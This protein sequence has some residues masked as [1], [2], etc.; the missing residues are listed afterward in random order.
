VSLVVRARLHRGSFELNVDVAFALQGVTALFGR[1]GCGKTTLL[2]VIAGLERARNAEVTFDGEIWQQGRRFVPLHKRR[3]GLVFQ[4]HSLLANLTVRQNLLYGYERTPRP[5]RR[6]HL[7]ETVEMLEIG[8]LLDRPIDRLSGGERQRASLGRAL[9]TSPRMLLLDE[10]L[11]ALDVQT[12]RE[13]MPF[14]TRLAS[15][16]GVPIVLVTHAADEVERLADRVAF[17]EGGRIDRVESLQAA[18]SR[19]D[20]PLFADEGAASIFEGALG[21][22]E[23]HGLCPFGS[24]TARLWIPASDSL[25]T[26]APARVRILARDVALA[27]D[28]PR[29]IS[30][31]NRLWVT[32]EQIVPLPGNRTLVTTRTADGARLLAEVTPWAVQQLCLEPGRSVVALIKSVALMP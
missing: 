11:A 25:D 27:L 6:Q 21:P 1:S 10:P 24:P 26:A 4:E 30:I 14:L 15:D 18:M 16:A 12:K 22:A 20:S 31:R 32:I 9:L 13:I 28:D 8:G 19:P 29:D 5:Q 3:L 23:H 7:S 17:M 2:R